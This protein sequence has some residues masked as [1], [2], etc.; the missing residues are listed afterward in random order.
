LKASGKGLGPK[1]T[2]EIEPLDGFY[3]AEDYHQYDLGFYARN[4]LIIL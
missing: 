2:T 3:L 1:I 4:K